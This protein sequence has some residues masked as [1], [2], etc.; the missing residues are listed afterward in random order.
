MILCNYLKVFPNVGTSIFGCRAPVLTP[1]FSLNSAVLKLIGSKILN[2][3]VSHNE[4]NE[5]TITG[6]RLICIFECDIE[7]GQF[8]CT[9]DSH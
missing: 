5:D 7:F 8:A 3:G 2:V 9:I 4:D 1:F 6:L